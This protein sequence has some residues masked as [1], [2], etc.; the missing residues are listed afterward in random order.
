MGVNLW[1]YLSWV[2][3][4]RLAST[5]QCH[6]NPGR[7]WQFDPVES[8][9]GM[10]LQLAQPVLGQG[11]SLVNALN[12]FTRTISTFKGEQ[13]VLPEADFLPEQSDLA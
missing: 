7:L 1:N 11:Q 4:N 8:V 12:A 13:H 5:G 3:F 2:A 10:L 9:A 6:D